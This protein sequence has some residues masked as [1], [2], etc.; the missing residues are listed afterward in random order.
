[1]RTYGASVLVA[2]HSLSF[3]PVIWNLI[4]DEFPPNSAHFCV[5]DIASIKT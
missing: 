5:S 3:Y 4:I 1:M 2:C